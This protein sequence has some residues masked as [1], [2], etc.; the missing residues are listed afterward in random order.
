MDNDEDGQCLS[1]K[2]V[3]LLTFVADVCSVFFLILIDFSPVFDKDGD[4]DGPG[5]QTGTMGGEFSSGVGF[6]MQTLNLVKNHG[7]RLEAQR[8]LLALC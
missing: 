6:G 3:Y 8:E 7:E 1:S 2:M 4:G 5:E